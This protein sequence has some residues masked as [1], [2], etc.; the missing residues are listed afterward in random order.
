MHIPTYWAQARLRHEDRPRHGI[1]IQRWGWSD[2]SQQAAEDHAR[3]R[4]QQAL[5][6]A[7]DARQA[8]RPAAEPRM[9]WKNE[10]GLDGAAT[11]IREEVLQRR[12]STVMTR[13]SYGAHCLNTDNVAIADMDLA[14]P[15]RPVRFPFVTLLL[16]LP[17]IAWLLQLQPQQSLLRTLAMTLIFT[18]VLLGGHR[19][20]RWWQ[21]RSTGLSMPAGDTNAAQVLE[22]VQAFH[23]AHPDW[24]LRV[25]ETPKGLRV[26]VTHARFAAGEAAIRQLFDALRVDPLY[27]ML[28]ERQQCFRARVTGKPWRMGLYALPTALRNWPLHE[29]AAMQARRQWAQDYDA[30]A[31]G[32]AAC[33]FLHHLGP[34][35]ACPEAEAFVQWHDAASRAQETLPLA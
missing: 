28:C 25:Y 2:A 24:G 7:R 29:Q 32:Y 33:R 30:K 9:E 19:A 26:I 21:A 14:P 13:N 35:L 6:S 23:A 22:R 16:L 10:Y 4:A 3:Q 8:R 11:P 15:P 17:A 31:A 20:R 1:T 34:T 12:G 5:D 27:A 18:L